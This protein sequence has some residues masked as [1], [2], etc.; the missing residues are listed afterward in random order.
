MEGTE[1]DRAQ[2]QVTREASCGLF[3]CDFDGVLL[4]QLISLRSQ[5]VCLLV[6]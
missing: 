6:I 4:Q 3:W 2:D 5:E 1:G